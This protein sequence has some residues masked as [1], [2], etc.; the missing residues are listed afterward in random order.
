[1]ETL[2]ERIQRCKNIPEA[3]QET[4]LWMSELKSLSEEAYRGNKRDPKVP[5]GIGNEEYDYELSFMNTKVD[6]RSDFWF[7]REGFQTIICGIFNVGSFIRDQGKPN[8]QNNDDTKSIVDKLHSIIDQYLDIGEALGLVGHDRGLIHAQLF[9]YGKHT[10]LGKSHK[11]LL[12]KIHKLTDL[13]SAAKTAKEERD[14]ESDKSNLHEGNDV[15]N[16]LDLAKKA[17]EDSEAL[18]MLVFWM[19][20]L[21][22][23]AEKVDGSEGTAYLRISA[24]DLNTAC[25]EL[26]QRTQNIMNERLAKAHKEAR[27][28]QEEADRTGRLSNNLRQAIEKYLSIGEALGVI[29]DDRQT[30]YGAL[31]DGKPVFDLAD[32]HQKILGKIS[33]VENCKNTESPDLKAQI[34]ELKAQLAQTSNALEESLKDVEGYKQQFLSALASRNFEIEERNRLLNEAYVVIGKLVVENNQRS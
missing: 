6:G 14:L 16:F 2:L 5:S 29:G 23:S 9:Q 4:A 30:I 26:N 18:R 17:K 3:L 11:D 19:H 8:E 7:N 28:R 13:Q 31:F 22:T 1:M 15:S 33:P 27:S 25:A 34:E 20:N 32:L 21:Q 24:A 10:Q 12:R